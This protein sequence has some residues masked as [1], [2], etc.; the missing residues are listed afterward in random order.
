MDGEVTLL[1]VETLASRL[2]VS[3]DTVYRMCRAG[4][5]P[6]AR[7]GRQIR[8][9]EENYQAITAP[10]APQNVK[11]RTQRKNIERLLRTA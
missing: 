6:Y 5:W 7:V 4:K 2:D 10:S 8:F 3:T 1:N 9:T 11:P